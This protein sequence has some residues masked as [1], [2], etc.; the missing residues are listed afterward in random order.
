MVRPIILTF[1]LVTLQISVE[2]P[3]VSGTKIKFFTVRFITALIRAYSTFQNK[4]CACES[5][6]F[7]EGERLWGK[8]LK[9]DI[10]DFPI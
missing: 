8:K 9:V 1:L 2:V 6:N 4:K 5:R 10:L 7:S 3:I